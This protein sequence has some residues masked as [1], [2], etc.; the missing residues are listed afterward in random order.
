MKIVIEV[1][2]CGDCPKYDSYGDYCTVNERDL[3]KSSHFIQDWCP[4]K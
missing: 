4:L 2:C 1:T 3:D